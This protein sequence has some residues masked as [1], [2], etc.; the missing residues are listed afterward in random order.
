M[1]R[2]TILIVLNILNFLL[3]IPSKVKTKP[4]RV[5]T[6]DTKETKFLIMCWVHELQKWVGSTAVC[7]ITVQTSDLSNSDVCEPPSIVSF[8]PLLLDHSHQHRSEAK[9]DNIHLEMLGQ[10]WHH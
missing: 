9:V 2:K 4:L 1:L 5:E 10:K 6:G 8:I 3:Q 7:A